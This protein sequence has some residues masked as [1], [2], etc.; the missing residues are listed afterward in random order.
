MAAKTTG[1]EI[2]REDLER[3]L[4][5]EQLE[6]RRRA[7]WQAVTV[8]WRRE[9][10]A[11][12]SP[13][14]CEVPYGLRVAADPRHLEDDPAEMEVLRLIL[15]GVVRDCPLSEIAAD[16]DARGYHRRDGGRWTQSDLFEM[17]PRVVDEAPTIYASD[18]W[19]AERHR[20]RAV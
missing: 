15:A 20:L 6:A 17:L 1:R 11:A 19:Q 16:L 7:G 13:R 4:T 8:V 9:A 18:A 3:P 12:A 10:D 5:A 14:R 2:E